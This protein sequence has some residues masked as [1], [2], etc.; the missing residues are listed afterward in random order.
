MQPPLRPGR[1][2]VDTRAT[3][4]EDV[5]QRVGALT[6]R[7]VA[8]LDVSAH[9]VFPVYTTFG[10]TFYWGLK[11]PIDGK[12]EVKRAGITVFKLEMSL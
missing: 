11:V 5:S 7:S 10:T 2:V 1:A 4:A 9:T 8:E 12:L 3:A 6:P